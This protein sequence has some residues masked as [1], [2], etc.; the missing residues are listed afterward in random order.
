MSKP[1]YSSM[2]LP[3]IILF[4]FLMSCSQ[5]EKTETSSP[6]I[7]IVPL[8]ASITASN[9]SYQLSKEVKIAAST[10]DEK[11]ACLTDRSP[12]VDF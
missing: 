1:K 4:I 10:D 6:V 5:Q 8:P 9:G 2:K 11:N 3:A 12:I 7:S